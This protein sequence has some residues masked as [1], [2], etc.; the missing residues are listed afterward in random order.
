MRRILAVLPQAGKGEVT[1]REIGD[2]LAE[3][4]LGPPLRTRTIQ[5]ALNDLAEQGLADGTSGDVRTAGRWW[6]SV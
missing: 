6:R 3:D 5:K 1:V 4:G 2:R